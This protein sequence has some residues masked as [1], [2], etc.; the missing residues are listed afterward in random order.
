MV[1]SFNSPMVVCQMA[2]WHSEFLGVIDSQGN[3]LK[4]NSE[5]GSGRVWEL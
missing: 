2:F 5:D 4:F 1:Q 3:I